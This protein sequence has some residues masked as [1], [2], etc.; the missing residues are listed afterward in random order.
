MTIADWFPAGLPWNEEGKFLHGNWIEPGAIL[1]GNTHEWIDAGTLMWKCMFPG[2]Y[3][4]V[5]GRREYKQKLAF[6]QFVQT[7]GVYVNALFTVEQP[8]RL[9]SSGG[10]SATNYRSI[11]A[12]SKRPLLYVPRY[13]A[14]IN[15]LLG[16]QI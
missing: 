7:D 8:H 10:Y 14:V 11:I 9:T 15:V 12:K 16:L 1:H 3:N 4:Y 5:Q 6:Q 13:Y 2:I